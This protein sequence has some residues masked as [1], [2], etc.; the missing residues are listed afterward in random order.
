[1]FKD[2]FSSLMREK[3]CDNVLEPQS[4]QRDEVEVDRWVNS[5]LALVLSFV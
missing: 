2:K 1:M 3:C 4:L 5:G